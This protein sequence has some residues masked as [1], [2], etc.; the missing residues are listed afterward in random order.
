[1]TFSIAAIDK[2]NKEVGFAIASCC[3]DSGRVC[4]AQ[5]EIGAIASQANG[6]LSFLHLFFDKLGEKMSLDDIL[7]HF[8]E[9]DEDIETRQVG[10][11]TFEGESLAFTGDKC[12]S[13]A[14]HK[15]GENYSCQGNTLVGP[16]VIDSM[17]KAFER[18]KDPLM[19]RLCTALQAGDDAGGDARGKQSARVLVLKK[20]CWPGSDIL[21]DIIIEDHPE[22]VKEIARILDVRSILVQGYQ[23]F[24]DFSKASDEEKPDILEKIEKFMEDKTECR[25]SDFWTGL[26]MMY[27]KMGNMEKAVN[28]FRKSLE[29]SPPLMKSLKGNAEKGLLPRKLA[30]LI[31]EGR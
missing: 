12:D 21:V 13:W 31:F 27:Y 9:V 25:Y 10:M 16:E 3:W 2:V 30:D 23:L 17:V 29:I 15:T 24:G 18:G 26:G 4:S 28:A 14:G 22:P 7:N 11:I 6:N 19:N 20:D 8:R 5:T 1:M